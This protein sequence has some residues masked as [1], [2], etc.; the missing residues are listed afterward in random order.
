MVSNE[1]GGS[2]EF[3]HI[4]EDYV[5]HGKCRNCSEYC[6]RQLIMNSILNDFDNLIDNH[7]DEEFKL[8]LRN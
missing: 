6:W 1:C 3:T 5:P 2:S 7:T 8:L 4:H